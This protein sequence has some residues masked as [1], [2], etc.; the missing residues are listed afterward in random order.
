MALFNTRGCCANFFLEGTVG[1]CWTIISYYTV[2]TRMRVESAIG[3]VFKNK[4]N[5]QCGR[6][7]WSR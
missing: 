1:I 7:L 5:V 2:T 4:K 3:L 6:V